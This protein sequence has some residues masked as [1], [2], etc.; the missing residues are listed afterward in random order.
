MATV[1]KSRL[2]EKE[3]QRDSFGMAYLFQYDVTNETLF[4]TP[5]PGVFADLNPCL[6]AQ[7]YVTF[8]VPCVA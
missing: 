2:S 4:P 6:V 1:D 5:M 3:R 8:L 7:R